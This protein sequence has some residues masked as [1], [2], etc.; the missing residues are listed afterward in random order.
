MNNEKENM[1]SAIRLWAIMQ[2]YEEIEKQEKADLTFEKDGL[3]TSFITEFDKK[4]LELMYVFPL[5]DKTKTDY[6]YVVTNDN[7]KRRELIKIIPDYCGIF[8]NGNPFGLG[9]LSMI[10]KE[11]KQ[12]KR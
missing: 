8:F 5:I 2:G 12:I 1:L 6:L 9:Y 7:A 3:I 11:A 4:T 10:L